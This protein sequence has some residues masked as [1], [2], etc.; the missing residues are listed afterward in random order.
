MGKVTDMGLAPSDDPM[1]SEGPRSYPPHWSRGFLKSKKISPDTSDGRPT[2]RP[3]SG[4]AQPAKDDNRGGT[5][6]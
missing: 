6:L 2:E 5:R 1:Y 4:E 3:A